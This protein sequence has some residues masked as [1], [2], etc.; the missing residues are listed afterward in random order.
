VPPERDRHAP[1]TGRDQRGVDGEPPVAGGDLH[2]D[3]VRERERRRVDVDRGPHAGD[4]AA[5]GLVVDPPPRAP[6][7]EAVDRDAALVRAQRESRQVDPDV[8]GAVAQRTQPVGPRR[9]Q[10]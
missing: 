10:R 3:P 4:P 1:T 5:G 7:Q 6:D 8:G 9:Q 2:L